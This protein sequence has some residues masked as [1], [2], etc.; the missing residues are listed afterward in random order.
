MNKKVQY[1]PFQYLC[2]D[3]CIVKNLKVISGTALQLNCETR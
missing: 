2:C 1:K 3:L